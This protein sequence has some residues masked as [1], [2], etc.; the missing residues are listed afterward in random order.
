M[1]EGEGVSEGEGV[2]R[3]VTGSHDSKNLKVGD[4]VTTSGSV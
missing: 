4:E 2:A 1:L 3:L